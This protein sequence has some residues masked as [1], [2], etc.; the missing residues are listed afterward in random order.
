MVYDGLNRI[1]DNMGTLSPR[2]TN[3]FNILGPHPASSH[4]VVLRPAGAS[5]CRKMSRS[6]ISMEFVTLCGDMYLLQ[7][8]QPPRHWM[9]PQRPPPVPNVRRP[10]TQQKRE[11]PSRAM[12]NLERTPSTDRLNP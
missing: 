1:P 7:P 5:R 10:G 2:T 8:S 12:V 4:P 3:P 11:K 9:P 6:A